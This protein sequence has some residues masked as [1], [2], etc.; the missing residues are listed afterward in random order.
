MYV[1]ILILLCS[2]G[3][4][5]ALL[6]QS[7]TCPY[8][9][10]PNGPL[11]VWCRQSSAECCSGFA[12]SEDAHMLDGNRVRVTRDSHSFSVEV[13]EPRQGGV[14]WCGVLGRNDT[15]VKLAEGYFHSS[16]GAFIWSF[17][18][19]ILMPLLPAAT[20]IAHLFSAD[21]RRAARCCC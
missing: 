9:E 1:L 17:A 2:V 4:S 11:R 13:K 20:V 14:Y 3:G 19:W 5:E 7:L 18:R 10:K 16:S 15:I 12:F 6:W 21:S 8:E